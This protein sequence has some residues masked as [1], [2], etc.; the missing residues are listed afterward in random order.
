MQN[1]ITLDSNATNQILCEETPDQNQSSLNS[2]ANHPN[3]FLCEELEDLKTIIQRIQ[4][5]PNTASGIE[6]K[7]QVEFQMKDFLDRNKLKIT[8]HP[9]TKSIE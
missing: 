6:I 1:H 9:F 7:K 8:P 2:N 5:L 4:N 3:Q